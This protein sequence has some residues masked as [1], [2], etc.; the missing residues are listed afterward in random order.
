MYENIWILF[1]LVIGKYHQSFNKIVKIILIDPVNSEF[2]IS[3][4]FP[5][6]LQ[7]NLIFVDLD[8]INSS[9]FHINGLSISL[10]EKLTEIF[11]FSDFNF[12]NQHILKWQ[13]TFKRIL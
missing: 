2:L 7:E 3:L 12:L 8:I 6:I 4:F 1:L 5:L 9:I 10:F 13:S 11:N